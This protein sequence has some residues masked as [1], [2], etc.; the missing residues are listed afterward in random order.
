MASPASSSP[1]PSRYL[2]LCPCCQGEFSQVPVA[3]STLYASFVAIPGQDCGCLDGLTVA[4]TRAPGPPEAGAWVSGPLVGPGSCPQGNLSVTFSCGG[5][6]LLCDDF[7][8]TVQCNTQTYTQTVKPVPHPVC[9]CSD[10]QQNPVMSV[11]FNGINLNDPVGMPCCVG[12][13]NVIVT[14]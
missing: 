3:W 14:S 10:G 4:L 12:M 6:G 11:P 5:S 8:L 9:H 7:R 1:G 2:T 13:C